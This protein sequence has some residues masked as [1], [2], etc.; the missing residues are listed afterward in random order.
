[1]SGASPELHDNVV[2]ITGLP[3]IFDRR[4][5]RHFAGQ[6]GKIRRLKLWQGPRPQSNFGGL[7]FIQYENDVAAR[8]A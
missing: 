6:F 4:S 1:M 2:K 7:A 3:S 5:L 8:A